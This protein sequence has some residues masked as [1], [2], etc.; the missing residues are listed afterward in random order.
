MSAAKE[1]NYEE[2]MM[3]EVH[4][5]QELMAKSPTGQAMMEASMRM[6]STDEMNRL[7]VLVGDPR[8]NE[9][10]RML[11]AQY[12]A[13]MLKRDPIRG[14]KL[15]AKY[16]KEVAEQPKYKSRRDY[17]LAVSEAALVV[18]NTAEYKEYID[19]Y[20]KFE[21]DHSPE[22]IAARQATE[23]MQERMREWAEA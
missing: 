13:D 17:Y 22:A 15:Y 18:N 19:S 10:E 8:V 1:Y 5:V 4:R 23:E 6:S 3:H 9:E 20:K 11:L 7:M 2:E 12:M 14:M 16:L 21:D